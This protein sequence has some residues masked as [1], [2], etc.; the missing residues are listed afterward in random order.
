MRGAGQIAEL[1][2][3]AEPDVGV[4]VNV[5]PV[6]LELLGS[7][8]AIAAAKAELIARPAR[9]ARTAVVPADEPL[10][11][12]HL[13]DDIDDRDL[14]R[15]RRRAPPRGRRRRRRDRCPRRAGRARRC[16]SRRPISAPN[17]SPRW[18]P[19]GPIGVDAGGR[20][21]RRA[22]R[23]RG[24]RIELPGS[25]SSSTTATTP[26]RC[27][28][29]PPSTTSPRPPRRA[30]SPC[31]A[32]C[33]SSAPTSTRFH[34]RSAPTRAQRGVDVLVTVGRAGRGD[35]RR[36]RRRRPCAVGRRRRGR[37]DARCRAR[38][39]GRRRAGQ[40]LARRS[41]SRSSRDDARGADGRVTWAAILI[42]GTAV[43]A[44]LRLPRPAVHR[45]PARPRVRPEHPRG[46]ARGPPRQGGH[47]DDG[48][49]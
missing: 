36:L 28:C 38:A 2:A 19:R 17:R 8:E 34:A 1:A 5:G 22:R 11:E 49:A 3:I 7:I 18:P 24:E 44:D 30:A 35:G 4:I 48:R 47:A 26:T 31:S 15:G 29:A 46:G 6:H 9:P 45:V 25:R 27:R 16:P 43:A 41:G 32:T 10:L 13:R 21:R 42:A 33:S 14:R 20:G 37:G 40:G 12:P 23:L 39:P